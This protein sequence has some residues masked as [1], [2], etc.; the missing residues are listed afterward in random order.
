MSYYPKS[1]ITTN[2]YTNGGEFTVQQNN[3]LTVYIGYYW[4]NSKNQF[5]AGRTPKEKPLRRI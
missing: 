4:K 3:P 5:F 1:Q 2:L